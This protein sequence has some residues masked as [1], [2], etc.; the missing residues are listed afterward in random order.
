MITV[1]PC[2]SG[3]PETTGWN[4]WVEFDLFTGLFVDCAGRPAVEPNV[5]T[6]TL[7]NGDA[8]TGTNKQI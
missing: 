7:E 3:S 8:E 4:Y 1:V 2:S 5:A 6:C